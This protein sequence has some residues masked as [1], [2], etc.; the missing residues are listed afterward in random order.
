MALEDAMFGRVGNNCGD[1]ICNVT[2]GICPTDCGT[3]TIARPITKCK[4]PNHFALTF[5]DGPSTLTESLVHKLNAAGVQA[6]V[7]IVGNTAAAHPERWRAIKL[8]YESGHDI[9]AH[10]YSHRSMG[11]SGRIDVNPNITWPMTVDE[12][13]AELV[14]TDVLVEAV[15]G[16]RP[17]LVRL[18]YLEWSAQAIQALDTYGYF[19][20]NINVDSY[21]WR[22]Q[23]PEA[24]PEAVLAQFIK[25]F[26]RAKSAGSWIS[27]KHDTQPHSVAAVPTIIDYLKTQKVE[28][29][30]TCLGLDPYRAPGA[31]PFL[32]DRIGNKVAVEVSRGRPARWFGRRVEAPRALSCADDACQGLMT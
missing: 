15:L 19:P 27:L 16:V 21:D 3:C 29:V 4:H 14:M 13:R 17:R 1:G 9:G 8:A 26:E 28:L 2:C 22:L 7:F 25:A 18:P 20:V 23:D 10:T 11:P 24:T 30:R 12:M 5:D 6:T 31:N 32:N